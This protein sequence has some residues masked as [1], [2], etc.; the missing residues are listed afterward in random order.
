MSSPVPS[1]LGSSAAPS[2]VGYPKAAPNAEKLVLAGP[3]PLEPWV[4]LL[5]S[6][7]LDMETLQ[8]RAL[9]RAAVTGE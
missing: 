6:F 3:A 4:S 2:G 5:R 1:L 7:H 9:G 8:A